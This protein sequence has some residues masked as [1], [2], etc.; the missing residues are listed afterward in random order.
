MKLLYLSGKNTDVG[1]S[2]PKLL[3]LFILLLAVKPV[4]LTSAKNCSGCTNALRNW[5]GEVLIPQRFFVG[6]K[7]PGTSAISPSLATAQLG[8]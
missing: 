4:V 1:P 3:R 5:R 7:R 8:T 6:D 2:F